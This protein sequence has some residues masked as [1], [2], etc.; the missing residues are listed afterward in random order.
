MSFTS[1]QFLVLTAL[2]FA[3]YHLRPTPRW[4]NGVC[5]IASYSFYGWWDVRFC[6]LLLASSLIDYWVGGRIA[7]T[8]QPR[9]RRAWLVFSLVTNL[10]LLGFFKYFNFFIDSLVIALALAGL[11]INISTLVILL[12]VGIS[13]YTFQTL[14]YCIDIYR[15]EFEPRRDLLSYLSFVSFFPQLV[16]GPIERA[17]NLLPQFRKARTLRLDDAVSGCQLVLWGFFKKLAVADNLALVVDPAYTSPSNATP[18]HLLLATF[19]FAFQIYCDFSGYSDIATGVARW[20]GIRLQ[21]NFALPYFSTSLAEFW[22]RWHIS[23]STW[24]RDYVFIPLGGSRCERPQRLRNLAAT[25]LLSGLWH[26]A[27]WTFVLW[28]GLHALCLIPSQWNRSPRGSS[29]PGDAKPCADARSICRVA[30]TFAL[31][32]V[33]WVLFRVDSLTEAALIYRRIAFGLVGAG[34]PTELATTIQT[35][36]AAF[37]V[38]GILLVIE[39]NTR[40]RWNPFEGLRWPRPVRWVA[41]TAL[42]WLTLYLCPAKVEPFIYFQF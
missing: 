28:G 42:F 26:G 34:L 20:F 24:F 10:G 31:V 41:Y 18:G 19:C 39:W 7:A 1:I 13:F 11:N 4:Q 3:A 30:A 29:A 32:C 8:D 37:A 2:A 35:W 17:S 21:R 36:P 27:A 40:A 15:R 5:V 14:S 22:R 9:S 33:A 12:P 6:G 16:A 23:L 38:L 25:F